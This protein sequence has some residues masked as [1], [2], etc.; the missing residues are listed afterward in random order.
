MK[1]ITIL[2]F[3]LFASLTSACLDPRAPEDRSA[4]AATAEPA[5][6]R[7]ATQEQAR[8]QLVA[9]EAQESLTCPAEGTC[10]RA[11]ILCDDPDDPRT[12]SWCAILQ[13]CFDC[14]WLIR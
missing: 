6:P 12:A 8:A 1:R 5:S 4:I 3:A 13:R 7:A 11:S 14:G 2:T 9:P 10:E